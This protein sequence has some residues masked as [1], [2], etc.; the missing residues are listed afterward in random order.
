MNTISNEELS[1]PLCDS[2]NKGL[3]LVK[4]DFINLPEHRITVKMASVIDVTA[5][6]KI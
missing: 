6:R 1:D 2:I 3:T 4:L 5:K